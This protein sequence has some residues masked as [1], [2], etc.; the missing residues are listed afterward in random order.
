VVRFLCSSRSV[1]IA[2]TSSRCDSPHWSEVNV[3]VKGN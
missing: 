3:L 2:I 1:M